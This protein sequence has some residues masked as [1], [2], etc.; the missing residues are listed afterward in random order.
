MTIVLHA[1]AAYDLLTEAN[2]RDKIAGADDLIAPDLIVPELLNAR[3][4]VARSGEAAPTLQRA[5]DFLERMRLLPS[6][7][8]AADAAGLAE[9][10]DHPM[11]DCLYVAV[12]Q[13]EQG[14]LLTIDDRLSKK[15]RASKL[16]RLLR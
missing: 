14:K 13:R 6:L 10:L 15:L 8:Y 3:W 4:N 1:S 7:P 16:T 9:A 12:A 2:C 11:Y 5:I